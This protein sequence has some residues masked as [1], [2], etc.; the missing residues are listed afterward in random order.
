VHLFYLHGFASS[1]R[2]SKARWLAER[3]AACGL[4]LHCPDLNEP[5]FS[6]LTVTRMIDRIDSALRELPPAPVVLIGSSLGGFVAVQL[7]ARH[8][9]ATDHPVE[10]MIL[11]APALDFPQGC[12]RTL[13][14]EGIARWRETN[15]LEVFHYGYGEMRPLGFALYEDASRYDP[16]ATAVDVPVLIFQGRSD[17]SVDPEMVE[18]F[19]RSR[20]NVTLRLLDDGHQ[21]LDS[22]EIIWREMAET[23]GPATR[24]GNP[25]SKPRSVS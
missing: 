3:L 9:P 5:D 18:R 1:A 23:L 21:L 2:S 13:G 25:A 10:R 14:P 11:L 16:F 17:E 8:R 15:R 7:A 4:A 6:T 24:A 20:P 12:V 22:L 19:A